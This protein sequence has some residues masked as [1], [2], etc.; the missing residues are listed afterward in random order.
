MDLN[1]AD[2]ENNNSK[3]LKIDISKNLNR[4]LLAL[5][6]FSYK[7]FS[8]LHKSAKSHRSYNWH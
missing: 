8:H 2:A 6:Y 7:I 3:V 5:M 4:L 1:L